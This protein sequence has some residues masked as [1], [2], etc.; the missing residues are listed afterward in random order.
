MLL[1]LYLDWFDVICLHIQTHYNDISYRITNTTHL[2]SAIL[3]G[4]LFTQIRPC[5]M[6]SKQVNVNDD[7]DDAATRASSSQRQ[8]FTLLA[9]RRR[10]SIHNIIRSVSST[11]IFNFP[12]RMGGKKGEREGAASF[13]KLSNEPFHPRQPKKDTIKVNLLWAIKHF[14]YSFHSGLS[15]LICGLRNMMQV[16]KWNEWILLPGF[17]ICCSCVCG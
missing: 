5:Q 12:A 4:L 6:T 1:R 13:I 17:I 16:N 2:V 8:L 14:Y 9:E 7:D 11:T 15:L 10:R 3:D